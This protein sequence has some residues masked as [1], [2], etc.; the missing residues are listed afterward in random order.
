MTRNGA[1][2]EELNLWAS[3]LPD[4]VVVADAGEVFELV[5]SLCRE[6]ADELDDVQ[7]RCLTSPF[8]ENADEEA[9][10]MVFRR[11]ALERPVGGRLPPDQARNR[12][13][14]ILTVRPSPLNWELAE[15][16]VAWAEQA[17]IPA[18]VAL[19]LLRSTVAASYAP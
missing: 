16:L 17:G 7:K 13:V 9:A 4:D 15:Y 6:I 10:G 3:R 18:P 14:F 19:R 11:L 12:L 8:G 5:R 2:Y 1:G